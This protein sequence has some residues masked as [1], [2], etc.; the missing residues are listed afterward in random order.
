MMKIIMLAPKRLGY[1]QS[2]Q[3]DMQMFQY[4]ELEEF[5]EKR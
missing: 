1:M 2:A 5:I 3:L 4:G